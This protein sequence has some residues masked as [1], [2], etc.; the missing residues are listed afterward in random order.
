MGKVGNSYMTRALRA[1]DRRYKV[2]LGKLGYQTGEA[3]GPA[4]ELAA[5]RGQYREVFGKKPFHAWGAKTIRE[6]I[7]E[8][9]SAPGA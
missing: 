2:I 5:V 9:Q 8:A 4:A 1:N 3:T 6:K 7:A